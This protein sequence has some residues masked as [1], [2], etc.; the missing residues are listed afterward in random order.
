MNMHIH[1]GNTVDQF[2]GV[3]CDSLTLVETFV[4]DIC[5]ILDAGI[6]VMY[7]CMYVC[8]SCMYVCL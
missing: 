4:L 8:M 3:S 7:I 6:Y 2:N 5:I 1:V